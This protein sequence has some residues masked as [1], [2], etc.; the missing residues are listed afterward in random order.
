M[1][2][3]ISMSSLNLFAQPL[4]SNSGAAAS[5]EKKSV[6]HA[7][8]P[9]SNS[10]A[11]PFDAS[12]QEA[13]KNPELM[14]EL[15]QLIEKMQ[16][17]V[18]YPGA[19][20]ES[21]IL[22][23]LPESTLF[24]A[25]FP[26][27]GE[28][29]HQAAQ[30]FKEE[31]DK[32]TQLKAFFSKN[33]LDALEPQIEK[34]IQ[35]FY[36]FSQFLG[37][38]V[39][40]AGRMKGDEPTG[41]MVAEVKKPGLRAFLDKLNDEVFTSPG[42]HLRIFDPQ[43]LASASEKGKSAAPVV[44]LRPDYI[45]IGLSVESLREFNSRIDHGGPGLTSTALGQRLARS[46][47]GGAST[48]LGLDLHKLVG[49]I[50]VTKPHDREVLEKT[51]LTDVSYLVSESTISAG[52]STS[53]FELSFQG[54]RRGIASWIAAPAPMDGLDFVSSR[55]ALVTA[56]ILK[57]PAE[58]FDDLREIVG[59]A[60]FASLPQMEQQLNLNLKQDILARLSGEVVFEM[61]APPTATAPSTQNTF[62]GAPAP[63]K[64]GAFKVILGVRDSA[65]LQQA[66]TRL[67]ATVP[68]Q[69]GQRQEYGVTVNTLTSP[70][71]ANP[72][73]INYFFLD[74]YLVITSDRAMAREALRVHRSGD[75]LAKSAKLRSALAAGESQ[76]ASM[77]VY[78]DAG[79]L[80]SSMMAQMP[81]ELRQLMSASGEINAKP[82]V[83]SISADDRSLRGV[84]NYAPD[85]SA[86]VALAVAAIAIPNLM[87]SHSAA[88]ESA[89]AASVRTLNTA[90]VTY[91]TVYPTKG[92]A[93]SLAELGPG[94]DG[95]CAENN[96]TAEHACLLDSV[97]A[98]ASCTAGKWCEKSGYRF[99]IRST[100]LQERCMRYV[101]TATPVNAEAGAKSFC[102]TDD[103]VVRSRSGAPLTAALSATECKT[104]K[105]LQ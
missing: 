51:G 5:S 10:P 37:D 14:K 56:V 28:S 7:S 55:P 73:E 79:K 48:V 69:S 19:R 102:S 82:T 71:A 76:N 87:R 46:Y 98:N 1:A 81:P 16:K 25:A 35:K 47:Q 92:Y 54:P 6:P 62:D 93:P 33:K 75:S 45:A 70:S 104:W 42:D 8:K 31:L 27:Y 64:P 97:L 74:R 9:G 67:L 66:L 20:N 103:A 21:G 88:N 2:V 44:L 12:L 4:H 86:G 52:G 40:I 72:M 58:M 61:E 84:T 83:V 39:V 15:G 34:S 38:E 78:Q 53:R 90:E 89:A 59:E 63:V 29:A 49:L 94:A 43:Q 36:E 95:T 17:G 68:F 30:I 60:A 3:L 80:L 13:L 105:P 99:A 50:P 101:V 57:S 41:V 65:A 11:D 26:N 77:L 85:A 91:A 100:C 22:V 24:Y 23:K 96:G 32:S 18:Q